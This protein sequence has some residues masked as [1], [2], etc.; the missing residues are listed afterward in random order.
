MYSKYKKN[1]TFS[2]IK[3]HPFATIGVIAGTGALITGSILGATSCTGGSDKPV[4]KDET[5][6]QDIIDSKMSYESGDYV[7]IIIKQDG[8]YDEDIL[9]EA[10]NNNKKIGIIIEP[11]MNE[12]FANRVLA[13]IYSI[14]V[15]YKVDL[16][17]LY[18]VG[19]LKDDM[20]TNIE[21]AKELFG[22]FD[23]YALYVGFYGNDIDI[24]NFIGLY[25]DGALNYD[26]MICD[27]PND[28]EFD[29]NMVMYNNGTIKIPSEIVDI[30]SSSDLNNVNN[31]TIVTGDELGKI[32]EKYNTDS[33]FLA[34]INNIDNPDNIYSGDTIY[35]PI[36]GKNFVY[37]SSNNNDNNIIKGVD[38]S[39]HQGEIDVPKF[40]EEGAKFIIIRVCDCYTP[41]LATNYTLD[42]ECL[43][44]IKE[45][46]KNDIPFALYY[47][48]RAKNVYDAEA[49]AKFVKRNLE[50]L[51]SVL[52]V[53]KLPIF[54]DIETDSFE[55][56][57]N[58]TTTQAK[59]D[60]MS[61]LS[62]DENVSVD[63]DMM[64]IVQATTIIDT[65]YN[66]FPEYKK[67]TFNPEQ[68]LGTSKLLKD[69]FDNNVLYCYDENGEKSEITY[70]SGC[71]YVKMYKNF[72]DNVKIEKLSDG[73]QI[74]VNKFDEH[75]NF[76]GVDTSFVSNEDLKLI[77]DAA[78][79]LKQRSQEDGFI[80]NLVACYKPE[81]ILKTA[82]ET[83]GDE[84]D[85]GLYSSS[86]V[87]SKVNSCLG[88]KFRYWVTSHE[89]YEYD[90]NFDQWNLD[91]L[92]MKY[93]WA[94]VVQYSENGYSK[95]SNSNFVDVD[96]TTP[97]KITYFLDD[98]IEDKEKI[99]VR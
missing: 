11:N 78:N 41:D 6:K 86:S 17:I 95:G 69:F 2:L 29:S 18:N 7:Y 5:S 66:Y 90:V 87:T 3:K 77:D 98:E 32:A 10:Y 73:I 59:I 94:D 88:N 39:T 67:G 47:Y 37:T 44:S 9:K 30:I 48:S 20:K 1:N 57:Q 63:D 97:D 8:R 36:N 89:T 80:D 24:N 92:A 82:S 4:D 60:S 93:D 55:N 33:R 62:F 54:I 75:G 27:V 84:Y 22:Q 45:C 61:E 72:T 56:F 34:K 25:G 51:K 65:I 52:G 76:K 19:I 91:D 50:E 12:N 38:V 71:D 40:I 83:F 74:S 68:I 99:L 46:I 79:I 15:N 70:Y 64:K 14:I 26:K 81:V 85:F 21:I 16:P 58:I 13:Q 96:Y 35:I 23:K 31:Y 42:T 53:N 49:E 28:L 43:R